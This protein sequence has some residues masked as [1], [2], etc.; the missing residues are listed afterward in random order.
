MRR[1]RRDERSWAVSPAVALLVGG[2]LLNLP[3]GLLTN[4]A[5]DHP[6]Q[7]PAPVRFVADEPWVPLA[8]VTALS[9][10]CAVAAARLAQS[11]SPGTSTGRVSTPRRL[12]ARR[13]AEQ[14]DDLLARD[15]NMPQPLA[16]SMAA[17]EWAVDRQRPGFAAREWS[18]PD[19]LDAFDLAGRALLVLGRPGAGKTRLLC[20]L[21]RLLVSRA[22]LDRDE[23]VPIFLDLSSWRDRRPFDEWIVAEANRRYAIPMGG[24]R[25]L[26]AADAV[27]LVFD[28]LDES[29]KPAECLAAI[30]DFRRRSGHDVVV[31]CR[32]S[33]YRELSRPADARLDLGGALAIGPPTPAMITSYLGAAGVPEAVTRDVVEAE[34]ESVRSPLALDLLIKISRVRGNALREE[35][36]IDDAAILR[37]Y[38]SSRLRLGSATRRLPVDQSADTLVYLG[39]LA[40]AMELA[41]ITTLRNLYDW[42]RPSRQTLYVATSLAVQVGAALFTLR[43]PYGQL[44]GATVLSTWAT[45]VETG[46]SPA[47]G[48][49][50][51]VFCVV[52]VVM[53]RRSTQPTGWFLAS[54][55]GATALLV[56]VSIGQFR[57]LQ[58]AATARQVELNLTLAVVL[59]A[60]TW[61]TA[62]PI[63]FLRTHRAFLIAAYVVRFRIIDGVV[64]GTFAFGA[65]FIPVGLWDLELPWSLVVFTAAAYPIVLIG[66]F[67]TRSLLLDRIFL[68]GDAPNRLRPFVEACGEL[69]LLRHR[70][71]KRVNYQFLHPRIQRYLAEGDLGS[72]RSSADREDEAA[73]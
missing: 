29:A 60:A 63:H 69:G 50:L 40:K 49:A 16:L 64:A 10:I 8:V 18:T 59:G 37:M 2:L 67:C 24:L 21:S 22:E 34:D 30:D 56:L 54:L 39:R 28:G 14:L 25:R 66:P 20:E 48:A 65:A 1:W 51:L 33:D 45:A 70:G 13:V 4:W 38:V 17:A 31:S 58:E 71:R 26:I 7:L 68:W 5:S 55:V 72:R 23:P 9:I 19:I 11:A 32:E 52:C 3:I 41:K 61:L 42:I 6:E 46:P 43:I 73:V 27:A 44:A 15:A 36:D 47:T 35:R 53:H 57:A 62:L 12:V